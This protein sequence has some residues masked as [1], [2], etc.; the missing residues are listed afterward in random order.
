MKILSIC[1]LCSFL[2]GCNTMHGVGRDMQ[3]A[4]N[5]IQYGVSDIRDSLKI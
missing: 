2:I 5:A 4:G 3:D 1:L